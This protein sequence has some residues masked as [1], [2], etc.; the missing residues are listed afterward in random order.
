MVISK[1]IA[2]RRVAKPKIKNIEHSISAKTASPKDTLTPKPI[3]S[4]NEMGSSPIKLA[5][6]SNPCLSISSPT[7]RRKN[8]KAKFILKGYLPG[9]KMNFFILIFNKLFQNNF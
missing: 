2:E 1:G 5:N 9:L 3:G 8:N 6:F 4:G 7:L